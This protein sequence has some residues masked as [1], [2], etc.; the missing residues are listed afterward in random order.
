MKNIK[1][2]K[3]DYSFLFSFLYF[4][5]LK[6]NSWTSGKNAHADPTYSMGTASVNANKEWE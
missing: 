3:L 5:I 6:Q 2:E 4:H 1:I